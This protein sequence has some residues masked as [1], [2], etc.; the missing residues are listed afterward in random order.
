MV[1]KIQHID[2]IFRLLKKELKKYNSPALN[3]SKWEEIVHTPF[4]TLISCILSLRTKDEV[5]D[6]ASIRLLEKH[7]TPEE[8]LK[9]SEKQ[10]VIIVEKTILKSLQAIRQAMDIKTDKFILN[11]DQQ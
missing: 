6:Q 5:T 9:L 1:Q 2:E 10:I 7:N 8:T 3:G 4:T 11:D